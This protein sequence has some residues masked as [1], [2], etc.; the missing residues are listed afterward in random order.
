MLLLSAFQI[1]EKGEL[2]VSE[3]ERSH[4][5]EQQYR[6]ICTMVMEMCV[7]PETQRPYPFGIIETAMKEAHYSVKPNRNTKQQ[8]CIYAIRMQV[9]GHGQDI[10]QQFIRA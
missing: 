8:V 1:L 4:N 5:L 7:N 2:Q 3:K 6:E 10:R 9:L